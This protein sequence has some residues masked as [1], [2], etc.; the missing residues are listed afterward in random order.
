MDKKY[1][2][3]KGL[4]LVEVIMSALLLSV[5]LAAL[6]A[7][8]RNANNLLHLSR[9][10]LVALTWAQSLIENQKDDFR[11]AYTD[12]ASPNWLS[13]EKGGTQVTALTVLGSTMDHIKVTISWTE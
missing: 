10:K 11:G 9:N 2:N 12:P 1:L 7:T 8:Y 5:V 6:F 4:S 13:V 3:N